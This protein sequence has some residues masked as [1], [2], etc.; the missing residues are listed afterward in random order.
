MAKM[1]QFLRA[2]QQAERERVRRPDPE[3]HEPEALVAPPEPPGRADGVED[4]LVSLVSPTSMEADQ[5][6]VLRDFV[7][8]R[9]KTGSFAVVAVTSPGIGDGK[10]TTAINLAGAIAQDATA[11]VLLI[12]ADLRNGSIAARLGLERHDGIGLTDAILDPTIALER[13]VRRV[14]SFNL[15]VVDTGRTSS[16]PPYEILRL[17]RLGELLDESRRRYDQVILD[18]PPATPFTDCRAIGRWVD[19]FLV[20]VAA[21]KTPRKLFEDALNSLDPAL[22][23]ALVFNGDGHVNAAHYYYYGAR[24]SAPARRDW[25]M[26]SRLRRPR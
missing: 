7:D 4:H 17:P 20:V 19:G 9:R 15:T 14:P 5:Y 3:V 12:D 13:V 1:S 23:A 11:R 8:Q 25:G 16:A 22:V 6:R 10:T 26:L 24:R 2:L 21:N 18:V